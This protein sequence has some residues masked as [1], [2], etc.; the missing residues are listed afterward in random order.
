MQVEIRVKPLKQIMARHL[1]SAAHAAAVHN[2]ET[3]NDGSITAARPWIDVSL[4]Q[5]D[6]AALI[7]ERYRPGQPIDA[8]FR[9]AMSELGEVFSGV[10]DDYSWGIP[11]KFQKWHRSGPTWDKITDS[12]ALRESYSISYYP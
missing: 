7:R 9:G 12:G 8:A 3:K 4:N 10:I 5:I 6:V 11:S 2:G 1:W